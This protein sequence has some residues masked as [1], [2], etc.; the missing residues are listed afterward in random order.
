M[1]TAFLNQVLRVSMEGHLTV[2][3]TSQIVNVFHFAVPLPE[4]TPQ[5]GLVEMMA[6]YDELYSGDP[7]WV[8]R[9][10]GMYPTTYILDGMRVSQIQHDEPLSF[11]T[12]DGQAGTRVISGER[13]PSYVAALLGWRSPVAGGR[14][15]KGKSYIG[16]LYEVDING[17]NYVGSGTL[18]DAI[19]QF[20]VINGRYKAGSLVSDFRFVIL[21]NPDKVQILE[22]VPDGKK[23]PEA[24]ELE[25]TTSTA[26][27]SM[28]KR[29]KVGRGS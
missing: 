20:Q 6:L 14:R 16:G 9:Y 11:F 10:V 22:P 2:G 18:D 19:T 24:Y 25:I 1:P 26:V 8:D 5:A 7:S 13:A 21:S 27:L 4:T 12:P 28:Q 17:D 29:R 23:V 15:G 3:N